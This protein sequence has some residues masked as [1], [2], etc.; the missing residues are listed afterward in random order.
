LYGKRRA[1]GEMMSEHVATR[2]HILTGI[3]RGLRLRCPHCGEGHL[4]TGFLKVS[5]ACEVCGAD[6]TI[7][8]ADD[9][10]PYLT[11]FLVGHLTVPVMF[12]IE[13]AYEPA[14]WLQLAVW[15]P[16]IAA[17]SVAVLPFAKGATVGFAWATGV[18]RES[19][20]Q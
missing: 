2:S 11:L 18:T 14:I 7:F 20:R 12:W 8:P 15:L 16:V 6:N 5:S 19:V 4:F 9:M 1:E 17:L 10:P 3:G 13:R